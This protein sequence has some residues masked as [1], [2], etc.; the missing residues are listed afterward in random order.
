MKQTELITN[1]DGSIFHLHLKPVDIAQKIVIVGDPDRVEMVSS[2]FDSIRVRKQNREFNT[3][4]GTYKSKE[5]TV[6]SSGIGTDN[7]DILLNEL[8]AIVNFNLSTKKPHDTKT[9]LEIIRIGTSGGLQGEIEPGSFVITEKAIGFDGV[10]NYYS[11]IEAISDISF[12]KEFMEYTKWPD[13]LSYPYIIESDRELFTRFESVGITSGYTVSS[14]GF[15]G[16]QGRTLTIEPYI[17]NI[18]DLLGSFRYKGNKIMNYEMESSAIY[19]L[20]KMLGHKAVTICAV[21]GN[22]VTGKF[23]VDYKPNITELIG[24]VLEHL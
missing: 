7:I 10:M 20:S 5:I 6:I 12:E 22:R 13:R 19:G 2:F 15:Y 11:G 3:V 17:P 23:L 8:D 16:P 24:L 14:P 21:I 4:T 1:P 18:N 9:S